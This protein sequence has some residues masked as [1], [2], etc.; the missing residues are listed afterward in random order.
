MNQSNQPQVSMKK[1]NRKTQV[2][3]IKYVP[4]DQHGMSNA[5][6]GLLSALLKWLSTHEAEIKA[7]QATLDRH[8]KS[9]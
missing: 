1:E 4:E 7:M 5:D 6:I 3:K 9:P 8:Q 2:S